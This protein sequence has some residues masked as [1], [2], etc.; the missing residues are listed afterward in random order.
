[1]LMIKPNAAQHR[2]AALALVIIAAFT[3]GM[4]AAQW[5]DPFDG[6]WLVP[7]VIAY[8]LFNFGYVFSVVKGSLQTIGARLGL[9]AVLLNVLAMFLSSF[10]A[11]WTALSACAVVVALVG[12]YLLFKEAR[13]A[14][15]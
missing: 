5:V 15:A 4:I 8:F 10:A 7:L 6:P 1:M 9:G 3:A 12:A 11:I 2:T 14:A 13:S